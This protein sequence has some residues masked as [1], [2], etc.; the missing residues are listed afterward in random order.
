MDWGVR[1][2]TE[3]QFDA[4]VELIRTIADQMFWMNDARGEDTSYYDADHER[5]VIARV[6]EKLVEKKS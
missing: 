6:K 1:G 5:E 2:M 4:L 3:E